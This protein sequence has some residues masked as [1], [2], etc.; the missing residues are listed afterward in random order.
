MVE[1][2]RKLAKLAAKGDGAALEVLYRRHVERVFRYA[3]LRT[4]HRDVACDIAQEVFLRVTRSV[5]QF[6]GNSEFTTWLFAIARTTTIEFSRRQQRERQG[7]AEPGVLKL[8][9]IEEDPA[10]QGFD[11]GVRRQ[12]REAIH[13][14][15]GQ[16]RD[17]IVLCQISGL[18][19]KD[20]AEV[21]GWSQSRVKVTLF[22]ARHKLK[23]WLRQRLPDEFEMAS[24]PTKRKD[25]PK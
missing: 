20:A 7:S 21:L 2:D 1:S 4:R 18:S 13:Q 9:P 16:Q 3:Y 10:D 5:R 11:A 6:K 14:L 8:I 15:P 23:D 17:A 24:S 25:N 22:R 12:V 19:I